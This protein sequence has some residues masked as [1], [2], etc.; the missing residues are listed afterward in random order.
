MVN[1]KNLNVD[2]INVGENN[3]ANEGDKINKTVEDKTKKE[4][5]NKS[6]RND[7]TLKGATAIR[8]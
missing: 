7:S 8:S 3:N 5:G 1:D 4:R 2:P 6:E